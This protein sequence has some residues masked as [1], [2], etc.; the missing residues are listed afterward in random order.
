MNEAQ[1]RLVKIDPALERAGWDKQVQIQAEYEYTG[2]QIQRGGKRGKK[3]KIDYLLFL[4]SN[5]PIAVVE[6]KASYKHPREGQ[7]QAN[8]YAKEMGVYFAF[9]TNG[10]QFIEYD[11]LK[12]TERTFGMDEFPTPESLFERLAETKRWTEEQQKIVTTPFYFQPGQKTPRYYQYVSV[13]NMIEHIAKGNK[14]GLLVMA[15]GVGKTYTAFQIIHRLMNTTGLVNGKKIKKVLFLADRNILVDQTMKNDFSPFGNLRMGKIQNRTIDKEKEVFLGLYQQLTQKPAGDDKDEEYELDMTV[16]SDTPREFFDLIVIDECHR[17]SANEDSN[18]RRILEHFS[19]AIQIGLTAT[20]KNNET[21]SN[22]DYF[23]KPVYEY[24]LKEGIQDGFLAPYKLIRYTL[25]KDLQGVVYQ[26]KEYKQKDF[27]R[28]A[29]LEK[30]RK[31]VAELITQYLKETDRMQKTIIFCEDTEHAYEMRREIGALNQDLMQESGDRYVMRITGNDEEGKSQL[32]AFMDDDQPYPTIV[33]TSKMLTTG[34]DAKMVKL[35]VLDANIRSMTEF[36]Q[37]IGRGTRLN[38]PRGK[39]DFTIMDFK[40]VSVLFEDKDFDGIPLDIHEV[41]DGDGKGIVPPSTREDKEEEDEPTAEGHGKVT[42]SNV[43]VQLFQRTVHYLDANG[44][45][46]LMPVD[47]WVKQ[48]GE[49]T[50]GL[51]GDFLEYWMTVEGRLA[52]QEFA[53]VHADVLELLLTKEQSDDNEVDLYERL[54]YLFYGK[55]I[56][57]REEKTAHAMDTEMYAGVDEKRKSFFLEVLINY[58]NSSNILFG[59]PLVWKAPTVMEANHTPRNISK[60]GFAN[61]KSCLEELHYL[62]YQLHTNE[63]P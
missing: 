37:I 26:G 7:G 54:A 38:E 42:I 16:F 48:K 20:P 57:T 62:E 3:R 36:K 52:I 35:I 59:S 21:G 28:N 23:G 49:E 40:N 8:L 10:S 56:R 5:V 22:L 19:S 55:P 4:Q 29:I 63:K 11:L 25:D 18:W 60:N 34:V 50:F 24:S 32:E 15:T 1:T 47:E 13:N 33:T 39:T 41:T 30:R 9:S 46:I 12:S 6:A 14:R 45:M 43:E 53:E 61:A 2:G 27:D 17:G 31:R 44:K 51:A 58:E